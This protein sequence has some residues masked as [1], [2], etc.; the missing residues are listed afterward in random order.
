MR[1]SQTNQRL[2]NLYNIK[3]I[4]NANCVFISATL[5]KLMARNYILN[6]QLRLQFVNL[7]ATSREIMIK[8]RS[9][10]ISLDVCINGDVRFLLQPHQI[11]DQLE[12]LTITSEPEDDHSGDRLTLESLVSKHADKLKMLKLDGIGCEDLT[13]PN[14]P[15]LILL[16]L[17]R[18]WVMDDVQW[19]MPPRCERSISTRALWSLLRAGQPVS[20]EVDRSVNIHKPDISMLRAQ[21]VPIQGFQ[22]Q[23]VD[24]FAQIPDGLNQP[25]NEI[26]G[27]DPL[28]IQNPG[29]N[30]P[31]N[32]IPGLMPGVD[33][34]GN[35]IPGFNPLGNPIQGINPEGNQIQGLMPGFDPPVNQ[36]VVPEMEVADAVDFML[37]QIMPGVDLSGY[38]MPNLR[39]LK[40]ISTFSACYL[41]MNAAHIVSL[42][43]RDSDLMDLLPGIFFPNLRE[44]N[45]DGSYL[46]LMYLLEMC[47]QSLECLV[48]TGDRSFDSY[49]EFYVHDIPVLPRLTDLYLHNTESCRKFMSS[50]HRHL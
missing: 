23:V 3:D 22:I 33:Q 42:T 47:W 18:I 50:Q 30:P 9:N 5:D 32:P 21:A 43:M 8:Y 27:F 20:L 26:Q 28:G 16:S 11:F 17:K 44:L 13:L 36:N 12:S 35:L 15:K 38:K 49:F 45:I 4:N 34:P 41:Q 7:N 25:G 46:Q 6:K 29:F 24:N 40:M 48:Y 14:L 1:V 10:I 37:H 39:H 19:N 31:G 2:F